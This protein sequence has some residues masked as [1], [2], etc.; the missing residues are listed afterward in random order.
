MDKYIFI[1]GDGNKFEIRHNFDYEKRSFVINDMPV[2]RYKFSDGKIVIIKHLPNSQDEIDAN[3]SMTM[4]EDN[5]FEFTNIVNPGF[6][7]LPSE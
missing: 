3:Y 7:D 1:R 6:K 5:V 2:D 4:Y